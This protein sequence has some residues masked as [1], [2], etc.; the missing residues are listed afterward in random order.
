M[1]SI[2]FNHFTVSHNLI[3]L[4]YIIFPL[5]YYLVIKIGV[6]TIHTL[7]S[8]IN[9]VFYELKS[10]NPT[11]DNYQ[12]WE[13][14]LKI[15]LPKYFASKPNNVHLLSKKFEEFEENLYPYLDKIKSTA[16]TR[17]NNIYELLGAPTLSS[18]NAIT[19]GINTKL[20][21]FWEEL[22]NLSPNVFSPEKELG[23]KLQG[24]DV[25]TYIDNNLYFTQLKT[26]KNTL[27]GSQAPR[28]TGELSRYKYSLLAACINTNCGWTYGGPIQRVVGDEYWR[29]TGLSYSDILTHLKI[30]LD[31]IEEFLIED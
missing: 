19:R 30:L 28:L 16:L 20:G 1:L 24:V 2:L 13:E 14:T 7:K 4:F 27:T 10:Q 31:N 9:E 18:A 11:L 15:E 26:Q 5:I 22:A 6:I 17:K 29:L 21:L 3:R 25:I 23:L 12:L 8:A